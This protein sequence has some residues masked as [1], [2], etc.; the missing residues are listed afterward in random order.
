MTSKTWIPKTDAEIE[1]EINK[2]KANNKEPRPLSL[3][4]FTDDSMFRQYVIDDPEED[5]SDYRSLLFLGPIP[6]QSGHGAY[7]NIK[8]NTTHV[9][10]IEELV[11]LTEDEL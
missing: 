6:N 8:F 7:I 11:E 1:A 9:I 4:K 5:M 3:V 10:D 2:I